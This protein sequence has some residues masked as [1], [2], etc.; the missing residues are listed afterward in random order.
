MP[1][2]PRGESRRREIAEQIQLQI[3]FEKTLGRSVHSELKSLGRIVSKDVEATGDYLKQMIIP[4]HERKLNEL[5]KRFY[6]RVMFRYGDRLYHM[7]AK[8]SHLPPISV[9]Q[10]DGIFEH[11]FNFWITNNAAKKAKLIS[12]NSNDK[13]AEIIRSGVQT[14]AG[15]KK[16][17]KNIRDSFGGEISRARSQ[18]IARTE[19][20][21]AALFAQEKLAIIARDELGLS[22]KKEWIAVEDDRTRSWHSDVDGTVVGL[23]EKFN[24]PNPKG[25][26]DLM[27]GPGDDSA[28]PEQVINCRCVLGY[29]TNE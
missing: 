22:L 8:K 7:I 29:L 17:A 24:V 2:N 25:G 11:Y 23:D 1:L 10:F 3:I 21:T 27:D 16:I 9:K 26:V 20:H 6:K 4:Q 5:L 14:N 13:L 12:D 19:V 18:T 28:P 15:N